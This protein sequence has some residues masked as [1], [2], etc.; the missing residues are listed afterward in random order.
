MKYQWVTNLPNG[1]FATISYGQLTSRWLIIIDHTAKHKVDTEEEGKEWVQ[2]KYGNLEPEDNSEYEIKRE[3]RD[4]L[5]HVSWPDRMSKGDKAKLPPLYHLLALHVAIRGLTVPAFPIQ[6]IPSAGK[7]VQFKFWG[8]G[9]YNIHQA[10]FKKERVFGIRYEIQYQ[11]KATEF[12]HPFVKPVWTCDTGIISDFNIMK[13]Y[14][15]LDDM[16]V[17]PNDW[18]YFQFIN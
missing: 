4:S 9:S 10:G 15:K 2:E 6:I 8:S 18:Q 13:A 14:R 16:P 12:A 3:K 5:K 11:G 1:R 7:F 17:L